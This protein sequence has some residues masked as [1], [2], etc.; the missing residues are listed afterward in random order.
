MSGSPILVSACLLGIRCRYDGKE[1]RCEEIIKLADRIDLVPICPEQLGGFPTPRPPARI[2][3]GDGNDVITGKGSVI[4]D[5]GADVT[6]GFLR[7]AEESLRIA[8][9]FNA[10]AALL[11]NK[12]PSCGLET[13]YCDKPL[14][15]GMGVTAGLFMASGIEVRDITPEG[16]VFIPGFK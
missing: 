9:I 14:G 5:L 4:N 8:K 12:S 1:R 7:G 10:K 6:K 13:P 2:I 15:K 11:K 3:N 16:P